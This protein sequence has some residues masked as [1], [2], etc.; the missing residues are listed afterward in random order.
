MLPPAQDFARVAGGGKTLLPIYFGSGLT[1][2]HLPRSYHTQGTDAQE[3]SRCRAGATT[4][5]ETFNRSRRGS[6]PE[7]TRC[8]RRLGRPAA[9]SAAAGGFADS[10]YCDLRSNHCSFNTPC[11]PSNP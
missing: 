1:Y 7:R 9:A 3:N 8:A 10:G 11:K 4:C 5:R 6:S 2:E